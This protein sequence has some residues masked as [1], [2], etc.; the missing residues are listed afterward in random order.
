[1]HN[2]STGMHQG[3]GT[4]GTYHTQR[5]TTGNRGQGRLERRLYRGYPGILALETMIAS[6]PVLEP[7]SH[8]AKAS[9]S[10]F[11]CRWLYNFFGHRSG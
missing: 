5:N 1:M 11:G 2:L 6:A 3:I 9:G 10:H 4:P 8:P 7:E